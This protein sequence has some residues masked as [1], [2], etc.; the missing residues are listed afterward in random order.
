MTTTTHSLQSESLDA[1]VN[2]RSKV[3]R[4]L[5]TVWRTFGRAVKRRMIPAAWNRTQQLLNC[6]RMDAR[7]LTKFESILLRRLRSS[8]DFTFVQIGANDG[9]AFD[10]LFWNLSKFNCRGLVVE[11]LP[12]LCERL[13]YNYRYN[14]RITAVQAAV[15]PSLSQVTLYRPDPARADGLPVWTSGVAS[16]HHDWYRRHGIPE[17]LMVKVT[18][19]AMHLMDLFRSHQITEIDLF[20]SDVEGFDGEVIKMI[21]FK[22]IRPR[23]I[24]Y[25]S[26]ELS[27]DQPE[28]QLLRSHGYKLVREGEDVVAWI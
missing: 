6:A 25:E 22:S 5:G 14:P 20:Q 17:D 18:V 3:S 24:K 12:D 15:H 4:S 11:P 1:L 7:P 8:T 28:A 19:P 27:L 9:I 23:L 13:K 10:N 2:R 26:W 16:T 21:D